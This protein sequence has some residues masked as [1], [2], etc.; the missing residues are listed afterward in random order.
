MQCNVYP[1]VI[2]APLMSYVTSVTVGTDFCFCSFNLVVWSVFPVCG[3]AVSSRSAVAA[4]VAVHS[5]YSLQSS[6]SGV[7]MCKQPLFQSRIRLSDEQDIFQGDAAEQHTDS[8][9]LE[10]KNVKSEAVFK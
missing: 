7:R 6:A 3:R 10:R 2:P 5:V 4:A 8:A 9:N 1:C